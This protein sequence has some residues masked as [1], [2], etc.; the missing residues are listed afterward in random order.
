[1]PFCVDEGTEK[2]QHFKAKCCCLIEVAG[3]TRHCS[4][5]MEKAC[6]FYLYHLV[7]QVKIT[8]I[9]DHLLR[10]NPSQAALLFAAPA[11]YCLSTQYTCALWVLHWAAATLLS[12]SQGSLHLLRPGGTRLRPHHV[13]QGPSRQQRHHCMSRFLHTWAKIQAYKYVVFSKSHKTMI[14][15]SWLAWTMVQLKQKPI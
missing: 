14:R 1:M 3:R 2:I 4:W 13:F 6:Y 12:V 10:F 9:R 11:A 8:W 15:L 5:S 7:L